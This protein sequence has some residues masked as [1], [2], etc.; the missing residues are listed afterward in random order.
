MSRHLTR[1]CSSRGGGLRWQRQLRCGRR[2]AA[3]LLVVRHHH[4]WFV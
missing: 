1:K 2:P 3:D 4:P